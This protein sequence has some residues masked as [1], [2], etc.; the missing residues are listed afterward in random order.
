MSGRTAVYFNDGAAGVRISMDGRS[1]GRWP[2]EVYFAGPREPLVVAASD[3]RQALRE[4]LEMTDPKAFLARSGWHPG[5]LSVSD[6]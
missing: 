2:D 6:H 4:I 5:I 3:K 1:R